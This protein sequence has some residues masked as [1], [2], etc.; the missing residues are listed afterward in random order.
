MGL[1]KIKLVMDR[2]FYSEAN[3]NGLYRDHL[4][5]LIGVRI[6]LALIRKELDAVYDNIRQF[7]NY[8]QSLDTYGYTVPIEWTYTKDCPYKGDPLTEKR[9]MYLHLYYNIDKGAED[10]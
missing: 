10:E 9:R 3:I 6:S 5:F 2:G 8:E 4:K 7:Q 1:G